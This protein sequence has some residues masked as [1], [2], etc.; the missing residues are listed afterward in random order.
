MGFGVHFTP[1]VEKKEYVERVLTPAARH[2][3]AE[4]IV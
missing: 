1:C 2:Q 4:Q 3:A